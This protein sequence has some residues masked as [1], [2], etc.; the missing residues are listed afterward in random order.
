MQSKSVRSK[1]TLMKDG[2]PDSP[3][4]IVEEWEQL[5]RLWE[6]AP[7]PKK[8]REGLINPFSLPNECKPN[9]L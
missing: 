2:Q 1:S 9:A 3:P 8:G 6:A 4:T 5:V 7:H